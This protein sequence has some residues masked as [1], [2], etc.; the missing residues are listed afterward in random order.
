MAAS[1]RPL[2]TACWW[3][4]ERR[5]CGAIARSR[6]SRRARADT[7]V[8]ADT[9][10][11][12]IGVNLGDVIDQC[13]RSMMQKVPFGGKMKQLSMLG[14]LLGALIG[15]AAWGQQPLKAG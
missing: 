4:L 2:A 14:V 6:C 10:E 11:L 3:S 12:H 15:S 5:R 13:G 9:I 8:S 1:S 7:G